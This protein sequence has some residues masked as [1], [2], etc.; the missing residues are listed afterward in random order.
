M[1]SPI[2]ITWGKNAFLHSYE[3]SSCI[4]IGYRFT[5]E[6]RSQT[7]GK[8]H[9]PGLARALLTLIASSGIFYVFYLTSQLC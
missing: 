7:I 9:L 1:T 5:N 6:R 8:I 4:L 2:V 3:V